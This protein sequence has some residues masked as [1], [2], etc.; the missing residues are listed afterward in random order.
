MCDIFNCNY[1]ILRGRIKGLNSFITSILFE[2]G[3]YRTVVLLT[4][5]IKENLLVYSVNV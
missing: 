5:F 4:H 3:S 2:V 1:C